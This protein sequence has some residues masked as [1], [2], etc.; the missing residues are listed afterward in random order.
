MAHKANKFLLNQRIDTVRYRVNEF[1]IADS[2][3][4][5]CIDTFISVTEKLPQFD[6]RIPLNLRIYFGQSTDDSNVFMIYETA[7]NAYSDPENIALFVGD[8]ILSSNPKFGI[9]RYKGYKIFVSVNKDS[10]SLDS[11]KAI[12]F[13]PSGK[14]TT[15]ESYLFYSKKQNRYLE[16]LPIWE[17]TLIFK[18]HDNQVIFSEVHHTSKLE[19]R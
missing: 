11:E 5:K 18:H 7:D 1:V 13:K 9:L 14:L 3:I 4:T 17:N 19:I 16:A 2:T 6:R 12:F 15:M 10:R 8:T